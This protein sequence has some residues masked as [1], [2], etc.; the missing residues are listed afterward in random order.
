MLAGPPPRGEAARAFYE[1]VAEIT[2]MP[3]AIIARSRG[4]IRDTYVKHLRA[5][6][7]KVV[8]RYDAT[9][10]RPDPYPESERTR[11]P[12]PLLDGVVRAYSS[13]FAAYAREELKFRT[14]L[15]YV[16]LSSEANGQW[17][18]GHGGGRATASVDDDLRALLTLDPSF[19][20]L[21]AH[22]YTDMVTPYAVSRYVLDH[23]PDL[24]GPARA[25]LRLYRGGH[26]FYLDPSSRHRFSAEVATFFTAEP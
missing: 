21:I 9:F 18:W 17:D 13:A 15:T 22:G 10:A 25:Q 23:L 11:G 1:R 5:D 26:M 20:L 8:S 7:R 6:E 24:E 4:F 3:V 14:E 19:R 2:G 12:D 16:L